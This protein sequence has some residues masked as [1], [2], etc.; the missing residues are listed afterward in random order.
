LVRAFII[1]VF[2]WVFD[3][4]GVHLP[5]EYADQSFIFPYI[6]LLGP[7]TFSYL[8]EILPFLQ[9]VFDS[10]KDVKD[11]ASTSYT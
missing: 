10:L 7:K 4:I 11:Q 3:S 1:S 2:F 9:D 5:N 8:G 6:E